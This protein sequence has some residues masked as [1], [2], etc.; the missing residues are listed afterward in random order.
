[1]AVGGVVV[2]AWAIQVGGHQADRVKAMLAARSLVVLYTGDLGD[3]VPL[4]SNAP[5]SKASSRISLSAYFG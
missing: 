3:G 2:V 1:M 5:V 4:G